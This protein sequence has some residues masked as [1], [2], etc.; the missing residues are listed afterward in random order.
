MLKICAN[1]LAV[2]CLVASAM[3][4]EQQSSPKHNTLGVGVSAIIGDVTFLEPGVSF[5]AL[6]ARRISSLLELEAATQFTAWSHYNTT[7]EPRSLFPFTSYGWMTS[8][9]SF[10]ADVGALFALSGQRERTEGW[11]IG[12]GLALRWFNHSHI[13]NPYVPYKDG[14]DNRYNVSSYS[15]YWSLGGN[16]KI[17]YIFPLGSTSDI[18][19]RGQVTVMAPPFVDNGT[20]PNRWSAGLSASLGAFFRVG[21]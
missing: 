12:A 14:L 16:V 3:A 19:L 17:E 6:Y 18:A 13:F 5:S 15:N 7:G 9:S 8:S 11:R 2:V 1:I 21:W 10:T 4:Q 20:T